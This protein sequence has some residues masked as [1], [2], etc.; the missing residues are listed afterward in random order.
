MCVVASTTRSGFGAPPVGLVAASIIATSTPRERGEHLG[1]TGK[2]ESASEQRMLVQG[3]RDDAVHR[4]R[5]RQLDD[6]IDGEPGAVPGQRLIIR[7]PMPAAHR[8]VDPG[9]AGR[10]DDVQI[11]RRA[12]ARIEPRGGDDLRSDAARIAERDRETRTRHAT[13]GGGTSSRLCG[14]RRRL[15]RRSRALPRGRRRTCPC[16]AYPSGA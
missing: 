11:G 4:P 2:I 3:S 7:V 12:H 6:A 8:L 1:V 13:R 9:N 16:A 14:R 5:H 10:P 15:R